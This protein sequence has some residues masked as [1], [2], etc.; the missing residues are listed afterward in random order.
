VPCVSDHI[1]NAKHNRSLIRVLDAHGITYADWV[2]VL[3]YYV[4]IHLIEAA[5][6][7]RVEKH[8]Q[9]HS[10]R[11]ARLEREF[12]RKWRR[13]Y[14]HLGDITRELRYECKKPDHRYLHT[15]MSR[16]VRPFVEQCCDTLA[17]HEPR[18]D[19]ARVLLPT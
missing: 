9:D 7:D 10:D 6:A 13:E 18:G 16:N 15:V 1:A 14:Q 17:A 12:G 5:F 19:L 4:I 11:K 2:V 3:Y 8:S